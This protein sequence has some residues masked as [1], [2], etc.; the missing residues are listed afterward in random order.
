MT[1]THSEEHLPRPEAVLNQLADYYDTRDTSADMEGGQWV[2]R[3]APPPAIAQSVSGDDEGARD[4]LGNPRS[5]GL[6]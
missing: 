4:A 2:E 1:M 6:P 5:S 3:N